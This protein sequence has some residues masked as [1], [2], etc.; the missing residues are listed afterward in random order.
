MQDQDKDQEWEDAAEE[1]REVE[2]THTYRIKERVYNAV[3][4]A[5]RAGYKLDRNRTTL[6]LAQLQPEAALRILSNLSHPMYTSSQQYV[7]HCIGDGWHA[8]SANHLG[9][10]IPATSAPGTGR[11]RTGPNGSPQQAQATNL[12]KHGTHSRKDPRG[13]PPLQK[14]KNKAALHGIKGKKA[15]VFCLAGL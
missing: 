3:T 6:G 2:L 9:Y 8:D 11:H 7:D 1:D 13:N 15:N 4:Q 10:R 5:I 12:V 14:A